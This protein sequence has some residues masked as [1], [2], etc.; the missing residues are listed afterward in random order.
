V[1]AGAKVFGSP[2]F[3]LKQALQSNALMKSL[4]EFRKTLKRLEQRLAQLDKPSISRES[5]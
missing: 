5:P 4:P 1:E 2:A 3:E